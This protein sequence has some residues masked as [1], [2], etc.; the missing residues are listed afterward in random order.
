[1]V[2]K[3]AVVGCGAMGSIYA[4]LLADAGNEVIAVV[5][6]PAHANSINRTGLRVEG[7]SGDRTVRVRAFSQ[8]PDWEVD[9]VV[10][11]VKASAVATVAPNLNRLCG[12]DTIVLAMQNGVGSSD[13]LSEYV[14]PDI[15]MVGIAKAFGAALR[16]PGHSFHSSMNEIRLGPIAGLPQARV[17]QV[18]KLWRDA[19][20]NALASNDVVGM[21]WEKLICN[22]AYSAPCAL[23][24]MTVG[25]MMD[26]PDMGPISRAAAVEAWEIAKAL[27]IGIKVEDPVSFVRDFAAGMPEARPSLLQDL[28]AGRA[29]EI[30]VINGAVPQAAARIGRVA[31]V[32]ATLTALVRQ[33]ERSKIQ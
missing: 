15:I 21:Q 17:E 19:G 7:A 2:K 6:S 13:I 10:L 30:D 33:R 32:N 23:T 1:M 14:S 8:I 12:A 11:A 27:D 9:L 5:S 28:E 20:F 18:A 16:G 24:G 31:P 25:E 29:S 3:I 26:D 22:V 4:A